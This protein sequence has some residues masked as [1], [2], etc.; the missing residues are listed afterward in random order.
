MI[1]VHFSQLQLNRGL[2]TVISPRIKSTGEIRTRDRKFQAFGVEHS[3]HYSIET[4]RV[5]MQHVN[6]G[7]NRDKM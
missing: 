2:N 4:K 3:N 6:C 1:P 7:L 5:D